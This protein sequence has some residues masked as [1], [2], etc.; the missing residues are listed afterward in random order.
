MGYTEALSA[1]L[2]EDSTVRLASS[3][4]RCILNYA[5][6][7][8][9][10]TPFIHYRDERLTHTYQTGANLALQAIDD[11]GIQLQ[12]VGTGQILQVALL[13]GKRTFQVIVDGRPCVS[14]QVLGQLVGEALALQ[15]S[16]LSRPI[17]SNKCV[18]FPFLPL[19]HPFFSSLFFVPFLP[20]PLLLV[21]L[22]LS[23]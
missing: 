11:G 23:F 8:N 20:F 4:I 12:A 1:P 22:S 7:D 16:S 18:S 21:A 17:I 6:P 14:D 3:F 5:Q 9:K 13:E 2:V 19:S 10:E 15:R